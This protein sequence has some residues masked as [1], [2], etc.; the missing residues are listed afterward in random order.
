MTCLKG[1]EEGAKRTSEIVKGLRNFSRLDQNVFLRANINES[2]DSCL[3]L[4]HNSY[5]N[6]IEIVR[7]FGRDTRSGLSARP[8]QPGVYEYSFECDPGY[9]RVKELYS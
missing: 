3:V 9:S 6:R 8:D 1:M 2:L 4:L 5:K 7:Q